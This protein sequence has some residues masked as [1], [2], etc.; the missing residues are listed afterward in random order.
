VPLNVIVR[1]FAAALCVQLTLSFCTKQRL[2]CKVYWLG[3]VN[4]MVVVVVA[5][6]STMVRLAVLD[7][8]CV[9]AVTDM[10]ASTALTGSTST[11]SSTSNALNINLY[12]PAIQE[13]TAL[14]GS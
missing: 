9:L 12:T 10:T 14:D 2:V 4:R 11:V 3:K 6:L 1:W 8:V 5:R 7:T 13:S